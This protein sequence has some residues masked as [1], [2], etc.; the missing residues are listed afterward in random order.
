[1]MILRLICATPG[2]VLRP[3]YQLTGALVLLLRY[4][5]DTG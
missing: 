3:K 5:G 2:N 4:T 1:M